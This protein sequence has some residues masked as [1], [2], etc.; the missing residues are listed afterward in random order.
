MSS[1]L[2]VTSQSMR[3]RI[4]R[5]EKT[6]WGFRGKCYAHVGVTPRQETFQQLIDLGYKPCLSCFPNGIAA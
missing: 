5:V 1:L 2:G 3:R 6:S 4:H